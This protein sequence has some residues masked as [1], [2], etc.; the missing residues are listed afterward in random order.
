MRSLLC[1]ADEDDDGGTV[2]Y[3]KDE[4]IMTITRSSCI[5]RST[6][7]TNAAKRDGTR[8]DTAAAATRRHKRAF[9]A[10]PSRRL[11]GSRCTLFRTL[12][13]KITFFTQLH[14]NTEPTIGRRVYVQVRAARVA[15]SSRLSLRSPHTRASCTRSNKLLL[16]AWPTADGAQLVWFVFTRSCRFSVVGRHGKQTARTWQGLRTRCL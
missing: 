13:G 12:A 5:R 10:K 8:D 11:T 6:T 16:A 4:V 9:H 1:F 3:V 15:Q 14:Q 2:N 7:T